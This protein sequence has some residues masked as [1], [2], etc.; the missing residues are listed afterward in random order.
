M[1]HKNL[2]FNLR[3]KDI[4]FLV[5]LQIFFS[6]FLYRLIG[7]GFQQALERYLTLYQRVAAEV[8]PL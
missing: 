3:C 1:I 5:I 4:T 7:V 8:F 2:I 6:V